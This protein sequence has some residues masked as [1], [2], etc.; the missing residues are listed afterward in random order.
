MS[1]LTACQQC[2][3]PSRGTRCPACQTPRDRAA[4]RTKRQRRPYNSPI[5]RRRAAAVAAWRAQHGDTCPGWGGDPAHHAT[6]LTA[7]HPTAVAD[8]GDEHGHL[9]VLCRAHNAAKGGGRSKKERGQ[10]ISGGNPS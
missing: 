8:G 4:L 5:R 9:E 3:T 1:A 10:K 2:G 6:D 7:D